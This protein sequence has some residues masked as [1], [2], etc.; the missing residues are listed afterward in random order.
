[1]KTNWPKISL[2]FLLIVAIVGTL[3][4]S[5][6]IGSIP[7]KY[8]HLVHVH[9]HIAFQGWIY[10]ILFQLIIYLF[11]NDEIIQKGRY[12]LQFRLTIVILIGI[13]VS[14]ALQGYALYS[15]VFSTLFQCLNYWF[16]YRF[17]KDSKKI[18]TNSADSIPLKFIKTALLLGVFST[19]FPFAIGTL[20]AKGYSET[21]VY[22]SVVYS[23][24]HLQYNGW[25]LFATLGIFYKFL[26]NNGITYNRNHVNKFYWLYTIAVIPAASLTMLGMSFAKYFLPIAYFAAALQAIGLIY[27]I[28]SLN[29]TF[30]QKLR[31]KNSWF[32]VFFSMFFF[33]FIF[34]EILQCLSVLPAFISLAFQNKWILLTYLHL[35]LIGVISSLLI[36]M[37]IDLKW[38]S[39]N[40]ISKTGSLFLI[41]GFVLTQSLLAIAGLGGQYHFQTL[42]FGSAFMAL[43]IFLFLMSKREKNQM[44]TMQ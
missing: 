15:I 42:L 28:L 39:I 1:M 19:L 24:M 6:L 41:T 33:S 34:K 4:R 13:L 3:L 27:F 35:S 44:I 40:F 5:N 32:L 20:S 8:G 17:F 22:K 10:T 21:E 38:L 12:V 36:S 26:E 29:S 7:L 37:M 43:G 31:N 9:S 18:K 30:M 2:L 14:F 25:F 16:I 11:L 23:F